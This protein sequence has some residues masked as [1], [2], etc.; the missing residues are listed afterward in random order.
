M[1]VKRYIGKDIKEAMYKVKLEQGNEAVILHTKKIRQKG[2]FKFFSQPFIELLVAVDD[3]QVRKVEKV[4]KEE[5]RAEEREYQDNVRMVDKEGKVTQLEQ[6]VHQMEGMLKQVYEEI[7]QS[8]QKDEKAPLSVLENPLEARVPMSAGKD[9]EPQFPLFSKPEIPRV[10]PNRAIVKKLFYNNLIKNEVA[11]EIADKVMEEVLEKMGDSGN[12]NQAAG[13][14]FGILSNILG[15]PETIRMKE[16]KGPTV[17]V[18][19]GPTGVGKTTTLAKIAANYSLNHNKKVGLITADTYRIAAVD[20][21][22]TYADILEIPVAVIYS[23]QEAKEAIEKFSDKDLVLIDTA[24]RSV[25]EQEQFEELNKLVEE[26]GADEV[27]LVLSSTTSA[28]NCREILRNYS[29]LNNYKLLFT[30]LDE[31]SISGVILNAK[32]YTN[33]NL[34]YFTMGQSVPDDIEIADTQALTKNLLGSLKR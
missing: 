16:G 24:G 27:Y 1:K 22:K 14:M 12:V 4:Q 25:K 33:K 6:K 13:I 29:F 34:S 7:V 15:K 23:A 32:Y 20:Q 28:S 5:M 9:R 19:L 11:P 31:T 18:F 26:S 2:W 30:K 3:V 8:K 17:V 10:D 21:L